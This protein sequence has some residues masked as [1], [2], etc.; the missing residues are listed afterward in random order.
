MKERLQ[1]GLFQHNRPKAAFSG[2]P[3]YQVL[4]KNLGKVNAPSTL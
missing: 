1:A 2:G 3:K 4:V